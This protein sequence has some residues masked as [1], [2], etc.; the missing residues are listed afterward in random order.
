MEKVTTDKA[1]PVLA[2]Q[3]NKWHSPFVFLAIA[4][5]V[6]S[7][8]FAGWMAMLNNFV[9]E[10]AAFTGAEIG[11]L[12]SLREIPGFLAFTA[13]FVLL[14]F[15][16][17]VFALISLCLLS[18]GVAVTGLFPSIYGLYATT[19]LMSIGFHY[20]E[21][22]N[23]S[24]SLQWF[25]K[26]EA[27]AKLGQLMSIKSAASLTCYAL[28]WLGFSVFSASY[29]VMYLFFGLSGLLLTLWLAFTMPK[30]VMEHPQHL[31]LIHI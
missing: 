13:I 2:E 27:A 10:Q 12:Q 1:I 17:Q 21:T 29:Q 6:M 11:M 8:T 24:L 9:I 23:T 25:K 7:V 15:T 4:S 26:D 14:V 30:F 18:V 16:E 22:L 31:S 3:G 28:I 19:V 20:Y 5:I